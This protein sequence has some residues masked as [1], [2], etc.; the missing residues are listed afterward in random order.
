MLGSNNKKAARGFGFAK[1]N[2]R[3]NLM[4][5]LEWLR[6]LTGV[7]NPTNLF[8][9]SIIESIF[10]PLP[11][12]T[13]LVPLVLLDPARGMLLAGITTA[14]S[15]IGAVIGYF[16]GQWGGRPL[17]EK[18]ASKDKLEKVACLY[19]RYEFWAVGIAGF[20]PIPYKVFTVS[21]GA[22][23]LRLHTFLFASILSRG[24]RFSLEAGLVMLY[25]Q[26]VVGFIERYFNLLTM[27]SVVVVGVVW[28]TWYGWR[29]YGR[30]REE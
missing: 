5:I 21:A 14:G 13:M 20:T 22:F 7:V 11:P 1:V 12:D 9:L 30:K 15:V 24:A 4:V 18:L 10:F 25:G 16:L 17:L 8:V 29:Q 19:K 23:G 6:Y 3:G 27:G 2:A 28:L 26:E